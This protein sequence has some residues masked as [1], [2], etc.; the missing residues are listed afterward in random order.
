[1][2]GAATT[3]PVIGLS[4]YREETSWGVWSQHAD[5]LHRE[6]ADSV[7]AAGGVPVLLPPATADARH[8]EAVVG[9]LDGLVISGG[10][11]V[12]PGRYGEDPHPRTANWRPDRDAWET[13]LLAAAERVAL[14]V[15]GVCRGMQLMAAAA[16]GRLDQH[17]PDS[18][19]HTGHGPAPGEFGTTRVSTQPGSRVAGLVGDDLEVPCH[20]HQSVLEHPGFAVT[21]RAEDGTV[22]AMELLGDRFCVAIQWHPEKGTDLALFHGLVDAARERMSHGR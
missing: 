6:Y 11:D 14:P 12:D 20:H 10:A 19:G 4:T 22:E 1:M 3:L 16:G 15:L 13:A 9:R 5:V 7:V 18:V 17:T 8:A 2:T 21:A